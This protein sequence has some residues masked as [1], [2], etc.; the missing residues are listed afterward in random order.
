MKAK[1]IVETIERTLNELSVKAEVD[2]WEWKDNTLSFQTEPVEENDYTLYVKV[3]VQQENFTVEWDFDDYAWC[4]GGSYSHLYEEK[5]VR[6][7]S[8][9]H[10]PVF[11]KRLVSLWKGGRNYWGWTVRCVDEAEVVEC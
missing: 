7:V 8:K 3:E 10:F 2:V 4:A 1:S 11:L 6:T 5:A 9:K